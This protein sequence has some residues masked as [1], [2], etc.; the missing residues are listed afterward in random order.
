MLE[1]GS[2]GELRRWQVLG[3]VADLPT[4]REAQTLVDERLRTIN[5][6]A[7]RPEEI[8]CFLCANDRQFEAD[9]RRRSEDSARIDSL[10]VRS[11]GHTRHTD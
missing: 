8:K 3:A 5:A 7:S 1:D 2:I 9:A 11:R 4:R 6:G 10:R